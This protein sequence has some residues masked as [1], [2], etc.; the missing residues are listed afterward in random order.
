MP[1]QAFKN[2]TNSEVHQIASVFDKINEGKGRN[3]TFGLLNGALVLLVAGWETYCEDVCKQAAQ[4]IRDRKALTFGQLTTAHQRI[5][6]RD[7]CRQF[8]EN[9]DPLNQKVSKL[10]DGGWRTLV[11]EQLEEYV[12]DFN[13]PKFY[14]S[15]GKNLNELFRRVLG[16]KISEEINILLD[17][18]NFCQYL[19]EIVT[20]R[21][22]IAHRGQT[23]Q[24]DRL[25][26]NKM[27]EFSSHF[28][29]AAAAIE[30]VVH[31]QFQKNF[32]FTP[33]QITRNVT[34][35]LRESACR[36]IN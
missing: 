23:Q 24:D 2:T 11:L 8:K 7:V 12:L 5:L 15:R 19:D 9:D 3:T 34:D 13:T 36:Q 33:W 26:S 29:E 32:G 17:D 31:R 25:S 30:V 18:G 21:G 35:A 6:I 16:M 10:P 27:R 1:S 22:E 28:M 14:R 20:L 4:K